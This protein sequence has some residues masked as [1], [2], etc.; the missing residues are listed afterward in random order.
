MDFGTA[1][2]SGFDRAKFAT[3]SRGM[4]ITQVYQK[5]GVPFDGDL[6]WAAGEKR[7]FPEKLSKDRRKIN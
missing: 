5:L 2:S 7:F 1:Y 3:I 4:P 6:T